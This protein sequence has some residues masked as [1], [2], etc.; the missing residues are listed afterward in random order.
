MTYLGG[1]DVLLDLG[2]TTTTF[3]PGSQSKPFSLPLPNN[4]GLRGIVLMAQSFH[5]ERWIGCAQLA[6]CLHGGVSFGA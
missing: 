1:L 3:V 4:A 6:D 5:L 2:S